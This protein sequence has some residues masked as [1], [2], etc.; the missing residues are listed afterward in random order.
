MSKQ[1]TEVNQSLRE[2]R[3]D[4][5]TITLREQ[6]GQKIV[7]KSYSHCSAALKT[8]VGRLAIN[9]ETWALK[10][11]A[12]SSHAPE[13]I[14]RP[15]PWTMDCTYVEGTSLEQIPKGGLDFSALWQQTESLLQDFLSVGLIHGDIG[16]DHWQSMGRE[17]NLIWTPEQQLVAI[18]FAGALPSSSRLPIIKTVCSALQ[19]HD[20]LLRSKVWH[21]FAPTDAET[22]PSDSISW[23]SGLWDLL[24]F[25]GKI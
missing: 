22:V 23:P 2:P 21:H 11:L 1:T 10:K 24:R 4:S 19:K 15:N 13:L 20:T 18:D 14:G 3:P 8:T 17:C 9:R 5:P 16:H 25:L 12:N 7:R 6:D